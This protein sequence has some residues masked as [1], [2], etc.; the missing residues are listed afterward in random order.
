[1]LRPSLRIGKIEET[2]SRKTPHQQV[3]SKLERRNKARQIA[4]YKQRNVLHAGKIFDGRNGAPRIISVVPLCPDGDAADAVRRLNYS[5]DTPVDVPNSG[6]LNV[7]IERF[8]QRAQYVMPLQWDFL[9]VL[10]ACKLADF[11]IF[12]LSAKEEVDSHGES[13]LRA[14]ESQ[15][16]STVITVVQHLDTIEPPKRRPDV[17]RSLLS[18]IKHFFP[19]IDK[20]HSLDVLQ[21]SQNV[22]RS[23]CTQN[24]KGVRWRDARSYLLAE[25]IRW[26][27]KD[28]LVL[29][30]TVRG[31]GIKADRLVHIPG[32][33]DYQIAKVW[34][35]QSL[36]IWLLTGK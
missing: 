30:G 28:G 4:T 22:M 2:S 1:M 32:Y 31:K 33:G 12:I 27:D 3:L 6:I 34:S 11:V 13:L 20:V 15:G 26:C 29:A 7:R 17:K 18:F 8:K 21:E 10:D 9:A 5:I 14:I 35:S 23:L 25:D 24:P 36:L 19:T 16:V